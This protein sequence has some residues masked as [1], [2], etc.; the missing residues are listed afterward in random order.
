MRQCAAPPT[1]VSPSPSPAAAAATHDVVVNDASGGRL[2]RAQRVRSREALARRECGGTP[3]AAALELAAVLVTAEK[4][5][6]TDRV[7]A[8]DELNVAIS[9][10]R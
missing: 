2:E 6:M 5:D 4:L 10:S 3:L 8:F 1:P 7:K 9:L